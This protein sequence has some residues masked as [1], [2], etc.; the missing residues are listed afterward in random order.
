MENE[1]VTIKISRKELMK[2]INDYAFQKFQETVP[3][4]SK[5]MVRPLHAD[6]DNVTYDVEVT[7]EILTNVIP[8]KNR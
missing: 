5:F 8:F 6:I 4:G 1:R 3:T 7:Y 2:L